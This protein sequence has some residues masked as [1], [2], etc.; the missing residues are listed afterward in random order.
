MGDG[1]QQF[2]HWTGRRHMLYEI[3]HWV[4]RDQMRLKRLP[5]QLIAEVPTA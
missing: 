1:G 3:A 2:R 4:K 5:A